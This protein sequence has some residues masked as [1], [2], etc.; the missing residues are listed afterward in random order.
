MPDYGLPP[1][2]GKLQTSIT[3]TYGLTDDRFRTCR[4]RHRSSTYQ[5]SHVKDQLHNWYRTDALETAPNNWSL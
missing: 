5:Q 3:A 2:N 4:C 1:V